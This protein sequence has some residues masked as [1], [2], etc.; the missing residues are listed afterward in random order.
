MKKLHL[1]RNLGSPVKNC[2]RVS[3][4]CLS[5]SVRRGLILSGCEI[6]EYRDA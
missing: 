1:K 6:Y 2:P 4:I 5:E 3:K